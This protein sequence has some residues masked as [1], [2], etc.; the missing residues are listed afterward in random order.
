MPFKVKIHRVIHNS[1]QYHPMKPKI[2]P[3]NGWVC[4]IPALMILLSDDVCAGRLVVDLYLF[5][6]CTCLQMIYRV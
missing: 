4:L 2:K 3:G 6:F 1:P 5:D